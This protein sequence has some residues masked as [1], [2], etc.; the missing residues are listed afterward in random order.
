MKDPI[1][2]D[3]K[4]GSGLIVRGGSWGDST[5]CL[6]SL[7]REGLS[8]GIRFNRDIGLRIVRNLKEKI[9]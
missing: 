2:T 9:Y 3:K 4:K 7:C 5:S 8:P 1:Q 6:F